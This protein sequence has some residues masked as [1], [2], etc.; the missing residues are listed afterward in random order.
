[1]AFPELKNTQNVTNRYWGFL[2]DPCPLAGLPRGVLWLGLVLWLGRV[3]SSGS[4]P[5]PRRE[6]RCWPSWSLWRRRRSS[7]WDLWTTHRL[8]VFNRR[9]SQTQTF[10]PNSLGDF[11]GKWI[12]GICTNP[13][14]QAKTIHSRSSNLVGRH[15]TKVNLL[16][17]F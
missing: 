3:V 16:P 9:E 10:Y 15:F 13:S 5:S 4:V 7:G 1:M 2:G 6:R 14:T 17:V 11:P 8:T 12:I